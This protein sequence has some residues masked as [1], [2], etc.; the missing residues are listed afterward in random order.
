MRDHI[1]A[2]ILA[3]DGGDLPRLR[4]APSADD[5]RRPR[6]T[7]SSVPGR[8]F[9]KRGVGDSGPS[10]RSGPTVFPPP[11]QQPRTSIP[12]CNHSASAGA[13]VSPPHG[14]LRCTRATNPFWCDSLVHGPCCKVVSAARSVL[15]WAPVQE[16]RSPSTPRSRSSP[17]WP[18]RVDFDCRF[19]RC[20]GRGYG[21]CGAYEQPGADGGDGG[22]EGG[23]REG[24]GRDGRTRRADG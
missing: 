1:I 13:T 16:G 5:P 17:F 18:R 8:F 24:G 14:P 15:A 12:W 11:P 20:P 6:G 7:P 4:C 2:R 22:R 10:C 19:V 9:G 23:G 3:G 21:R